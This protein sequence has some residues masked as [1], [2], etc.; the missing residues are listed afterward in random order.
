MIAVNDLRRSI[1]QQGNIDR[2][3][4]RIRLATGILVT[5]SS[6][7]GEVI[8]GLRHGDPG[9]RLLLFFPLQYGVLG[10]LQGSCGI[11]I[12][13]AA[14]GSWKVRHCGVQKIPDPHL[15]HC[16]K[17]TAKRIAIASALISGAVTVIFALL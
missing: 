13:Y 3:G 7:A 2:H 6:L 5:L 12:A 9:W 1:G 16:F 17:V 4:R 11:C 14:M 10:I 15:E 8:L